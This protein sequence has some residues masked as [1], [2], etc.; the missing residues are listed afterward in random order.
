M[1][2][3]DADADK[4]H[5]SWEAELAE[6]LCLLVKQF[7]VALVPETLAIDDFYSD[8]TASVLAFA[9]FGEET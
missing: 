9:H 3:P 4:L 7:D 1:L 5:H 6:N 2:I 8:G